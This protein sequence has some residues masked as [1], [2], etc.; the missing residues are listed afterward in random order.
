[1]TELQACLGNVEISIL[2]VIF[3][4]ISIDGFSSIHKYC[5]ACSN[6]QAKPQIVFP[7]EQ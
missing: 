1:M 2:Y 6:I 3:E 5:A 7:I 4:F